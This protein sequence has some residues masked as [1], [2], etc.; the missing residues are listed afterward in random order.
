M[1]ITRV[2]AIPVRVPLKKG[3]TT[4]TA[5][6][7]QV[8]S[9]YVVVRVHTDEGLVGLGEATVAPLWDGETSP[10]CVA[11]IH[12]ILGPALAGED[13]RGITALR[14]KMDRC[15]KLNPFAKA[16]VE[17]A[18]WDLLGKAAGLPV[19]QL[20]GGK[21]RDAVPIKMVIGAFEVREAVRLAEQFLGWGVKCL[22]VKTG[23]DPAGDVARV[24]AVREA[25]GPQVPIGIDSN[26]GWDVA[27]ARRVLH[28]L[29]PYGILFAEQPVPPDDPEALAEVRRATDIPVMAD[30]SVFT[31]GDAWRVAR[32]R[33]ADVL[34]VY[35]GK[36]GGIAATLEVTHLARAAGLACAIGS[37]LEL[38]IGTAAMLHV[39][40]ADPTIDSV[41]YPADLIGPLYHDADLLTQRLTLGPAAAR[42]PEGPGL[43]V[44]LS[45]EDLALYRQR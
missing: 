37:N 29:R 20:L 3:M 31:L 11:V 30:E 1:K 25:A 9:P 35:P 14:Q 15:L 40:V 28:E 39:A 38:G 32:H 33:A 24:K 27:T 13:P 7:E 45:E 10:G 23:L 18:L 16:A 5:H 12:D 21:V 19:Y 6:G 44:E 17:M 43:G 42:V 34:S 26:C 36:H 8:E 41:K 2:E 4:K 22:K